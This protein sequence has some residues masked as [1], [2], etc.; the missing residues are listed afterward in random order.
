MKATWSV[1]FVCTYFAHPD[2]WW[3]NVGS[4]LPIFI[5]IQLTKWGLLPFV[6]FFLGRVGYTPLGAPCDYIVAIRA[7]SNVAI[8]F[9]INVCWPYKLPSLTSTMMPLKYQVLVESMS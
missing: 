2:Y 6:K 3:S 9:V 7:H 5:L 4:T 1:N 8:P